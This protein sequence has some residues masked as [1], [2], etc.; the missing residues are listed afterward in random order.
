M[1]QQDIVWKNLQIQCFLTMTCLSNGV[2]IST[3]QTELVFFGCKSPHTHTHTLTKQT[4]QL[5]SKRTNVNSFAG[6]QWAFTIRNI[7]QYMK[8]KNKEAKKRKNYRVLHILRVY[9]MFV[10]RNVSCAEHKCI[11]RYTDT[12]YSGFITYREFS[13]S[14]SV[15][16]EL[17]C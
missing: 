16:G 13:Y 2:P 4:I 3:D 14:P 15:F 6:L 9:G 1:I 12:N 17:S 8:K 5:N 11:N 10:E 7:A